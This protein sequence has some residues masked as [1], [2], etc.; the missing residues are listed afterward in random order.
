MNTKLMLSVLS[1]V[2]VTL[3]GVCAPAA[4]E[5]KAP[6]PAPA[7]WQGRKVAMLGDSITDPRQGHRI[8]WQY[9]TSWLG[10]QTKVYGVSGHAWNN[11]PGQMDRMVKEMG[12]DVD[13][14]FIFIGT[15]DYCAGRPLGKW[16]D[17]KEGS[18]NW[19][20]KERTLKQRVLSRDTKTVRGMINVALERLKKRYPDTQIVLMT[21]TK[22]AFFQCSPT[23]VQPA[24]DWPNTA[25]LYVDDYVQ[26]VREAG[27]V[28]SCPVID[29]FGESGF[30]PCTE[31]YAKYVRNK[32]KDGLHPNGLG[33][34]RLARLIYHRL[35]AL[36][37]TFRDCVGK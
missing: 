1:F 34:E 23:N 5:A 29:L 28:W 14:I 16:Y 19:W 30:L 24:E 17:E 9:L 7:Q 31:G 8:Y 36:P 33:H 26:C 10:W 22:R 13:A 11:I 20:G 12:D 18:V 15:N 27:Q 3:T 37:G 21:P 6:A 4:V 2:A 25:G 35:S 32:D